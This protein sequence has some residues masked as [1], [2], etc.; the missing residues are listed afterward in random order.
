M[1]LVLQPMAQQFGSAVQTASQQSG[2]LH[3]AET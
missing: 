3:P 1:Q 2:S